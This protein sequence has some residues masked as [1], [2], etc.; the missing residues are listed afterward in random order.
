MNRFTATTLLKRLLLAFVAVAAIVWAF[1]WLDANRADPEEFSQEYLHSRATVSEHVDFSEW[2]S[3]RP[4][5]VQAP[6]QTGWELLREY[7]YRVAMRQPMGGVQGEYDRQEDE[8]RI[9]GDEVRY[10]ATL[11]EPLR[12]NFYH[13][14]RHEY[15]HAAFFD[16]ADEQDLDSET[17]VLISLSQPN[18]PPRDELLPTRLRPVV[19]E[20]TALET[21]V[22]GD[23]Y[24]MSNFA[25]YIA[26]SYARV[27]AGRP[28]PPRTWAFVMDAYRGREL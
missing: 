8:I 23:P 6:E 20:W 14:L 18:S 16:W 1:E 13:T 12:A 19:R 17:T 21:T 10:E 22:Y 15:G 7:A 2:V 28:V 11:P 26:E 5:V 25:E 9:L 3:Q 4:V 27:M 24:F